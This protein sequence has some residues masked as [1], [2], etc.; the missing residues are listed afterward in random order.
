MALTAGLASG[1]RSAKFARKS[2][3]LPAWKKSSAAELAR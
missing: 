1:M 3:A 2:A